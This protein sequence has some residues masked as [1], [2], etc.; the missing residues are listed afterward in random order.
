MV[1]TLDLEEWRP[2]GGENL[3]MSNSTGL[4]EPRIVGQ[5]IDTGA[6][7]SVVSSSFQ[8]GRHR[9]Y[10]YIGHDL[11]Q[12]CTE[13]LPVIFLKVQYYGLL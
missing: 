5:T 6:L 10:I 9:K 7:L 1:S 8:D 11:L 2:K 4:P 13:I 3:K 12:G